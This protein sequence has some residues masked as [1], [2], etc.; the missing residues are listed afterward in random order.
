MAQADLK[1]PTSKRG[2]GGGGVS[3]AQGAAAVAVAISDDESPPP[4]SVVGGS[5]S[6]E[7]WPQELSESNEQNTDKQKQ[8]NIAFQGAARANTE[9]MDN[10][11]VGSLSGSASALLDPLAATA[12]APQQSPKSEVPDHLPNPLEA[13][14]M[15]KAAKA[16]AT[17]ATAAAHAPPAAKGGSRSATV[18]PKAAGGAGKGGKAKGKGKVFQGPPPI[19][20]VSGADAAEGF[21]STTVQP[22][23]SAPVPGVGA[24]MAGKRPCAHRRRRRP[25]RARRRRRRR[26]VPCQKLLQVAGRRRRRQPRCYSRPGSTPSWVSIGP[27]LRGWLQAQLPP[28]SYTAIVKHYE[29]LCAAQDAAQPS[30]GADTQASEQPKHSQWCWG[31]GC[32]MSDKQFYNKERSSDPKHKQICTAAWAALDTEWRHIKDTVIDCYYCNECGETKHERLFTAKMQNK[33]PQRYG[34][35][36]FRFCTKCFDRLQYAYYGEGWTPDAPSGPPTKGYGQPTQEAMYAWAEDQWP[37]LQKELEQPPL[38]GYVKAATAAAVAVPAAAAAAAVHTAAAA[39][40][41]AAPMVPAAPE[42]VVASAAGAV[43]AS[44]MAVPLPSPTESADAPDFSCSAPDDQT[45]SVPNVGPMGGAHAP[46]PRRPVE[47]TAE[48]RQPVAYLSMMEPLGIM[49]R[50]VREHG[51]MLLLSIKAGTV[52]EQQILYW[53]ATHP[54]LEIHPGA[55]IVMIDDIV[56]VSDQAPGRSELSLAYRTA[57]SH[58]STPQVRRIGFVP[59]RTMPAESGDEPLFLEDMVNIRMTH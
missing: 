38:E 41:S 12:M 2:G 10:V 43:P 35:D 31:F 53:N 54:G 16:A 40:T 52:G 48:L 9:G 34:K 55:C 56:G 50:Y 15:A 21:R 36:G 27:R 26:S 3:S 1:P 59:E 14:K 51:Y 24:T 49:A 29:T 45:A 42:P 8:S 37:K 58:S 22:I 19:P 30:G 47:M 23:A 25:R 17:A 44:A 32:F 4:G 11:D 33:D 20:G 39:A 6:D 13:K 18:Q 7:W 5:L 57:I 46:Q 28:E